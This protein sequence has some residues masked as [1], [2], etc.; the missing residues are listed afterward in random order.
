MPSP[1]NQPDKRRRRSQSVGDLKKLLAAAE[2]SD[3][4]RQA[5]PQKKRERRRKRNSLVRAIDKLIS[6]A[7]ISV[8]NKE[9]HA[10]EAP[11]HS[12]VEKEQKPEPPVEQLAPPQEQ[13]E[14]CTEDMDCSDLSIRGGT[15]QEIFKFVALSNWKQIEESSG[16]DS[17]ATKRIAVWRDRSLAIN[18]LFGLSRWKMTIS[19]LRLM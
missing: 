12:K 5:P 16:E 1:A 10:P 11:A 9:G 14:T 4:A 8:N 19:L 17:C 3:A 13:E 18:F 6:V 7:G 15:L 2:A